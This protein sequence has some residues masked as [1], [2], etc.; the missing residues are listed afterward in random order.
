MT[1]LQESEMLYTEGLNLMELEHT[2]EAIRKFIEALKKFHQVASPP[3]RM[4]HLVEIALASCM[5]DAGNTWRPG[6]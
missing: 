4:T 3:H 1:E 6:C 5:A 2:D